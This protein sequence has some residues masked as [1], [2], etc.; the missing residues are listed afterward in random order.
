MRETPPDRLEEYWQN[1]VHNGADN[2]LKRFF[3]VG[4]CFFCFDQIEIL[5]DY[6]ENRISEKKKRK[7]RRPRS[8]GAKPYPGSP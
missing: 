1:L 6:C 2:L 8:L 3:N 7:N 4:A 5:F